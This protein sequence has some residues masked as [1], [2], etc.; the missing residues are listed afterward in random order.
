MADPSDRLDQLQQQLASLL[1]RVHVLE[2]RSAP[3]DVPTGP[4][5]AP[6]GESGGGDTGA[7][8]FLSYEGSVEC[9]LCDGPKTGQQLE[10]SAGISSTGQ[11]YHHLKELLA[12]GLVTQPARS[13]YALRPQAVVGICTALMLAGDLASRPGN[14]SAPPADSDAE[15]W[16][17]DI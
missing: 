17:E 11:L 14:A 6:D 7:R 5:H 4:R 16:P 12:A 2:Q 3:A 8:G 15:P 13:L 10:D 9:A 1:E